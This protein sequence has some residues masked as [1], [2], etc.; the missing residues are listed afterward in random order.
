MYPNCIRIGTEFFTQ[1][2]T[3]KQ[4]VNVKSRKESNANQKCGGLLISYFWSSI[5]AHYSEIFV[6]QH[7]K[8][9]WRLTDSSGREIWMRSSLE[10]KHTYAF[11]DVNIPIT[12][13]QTKWFK[14]QSFHSSL[15]Q[16]RSAFKTLVYFLP[17]KPIH[18]KSFLHT[19]VIRR[20]CRNQLNVCVGYVSLQVYSFPTLTQSLPL[21]V[22]NTIKVWI[23]VCWCECENWQICAEQTSICIAKITIFTYIYVYMY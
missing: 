17:K 11:E 19:F 5:V 6:E 4:G 22:N 10:S 14:L 21:K 2:W 13:R 18:F 23:S 20:W 16:M 9:C 12:F 1:W 8:L 7:N 3:G 15:K